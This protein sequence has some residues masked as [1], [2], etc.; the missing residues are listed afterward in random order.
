VEAADWGASR[1]SMFVTLKALMVLAARRA[2]MTSGRL[3]ATQMLY[4][5]FN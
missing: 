4:P 5:V 1:P 3:C 2:P